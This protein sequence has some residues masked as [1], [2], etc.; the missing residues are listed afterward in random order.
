M[1]ASDSQLAEQ[2]SSESAEERISSDS[3]NENW[4]VNGES[5]ATFED[6]MKQ[7]PPLE[8][9]RPILI[10]E[11]P[12]EKRPMVSVGMLLEDEDEEDNAGA[13]SCAELEEEELTEDPII[14][15]CV[16]AGACRT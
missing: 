12:P 6:M 14:P 11:I 7:N 10:T 3:G 16:T 1:G 15:S 2:K 9:A 4:W 5:G 13:T 8:S